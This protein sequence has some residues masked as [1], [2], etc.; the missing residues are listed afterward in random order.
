M[1]QVKPGFSERLFATC[2]W[3]VSSER[4]LRTDYLT[5]HSR[6]VASNG[7]CGFDN[8]AMPRLSSAAHRKRGSPKGNGSGKAKP[9]KQGLSPAEKRA[10][11]I[12]AKKAKDREVDHVD[13][14]HAEE[15]SSEI[16]E[17]GSEKGSGGGTR[18]EESVPR[19]GTLSTTS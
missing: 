16:D 10:A 5:R 19:C 15:E 17:E 1:R 3:I 13:Q 7:S 11:T 8:F 18:W 4:G 12:A 2:L 9:P 14:D 6:G